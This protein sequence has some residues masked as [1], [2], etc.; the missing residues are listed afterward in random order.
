MDV[1]ITES[2]DI[3]KLKIPQ[4]NDENKIKNQDQGNHIQGSRCYFSSILTNHI[5]RSCFLDRLQQS[6]KH[7]NKI[8]D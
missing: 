5:L 8:K 2:R 4:I 7:I 1:H 6:L 3:V